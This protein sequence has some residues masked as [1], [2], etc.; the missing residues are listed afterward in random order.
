MRTLKTLSTCVLTVAL[1]LLTMPFAFAESKLQSGIT[2][3]NETQG[4]DGTKVKAKPGDVLH[5][6]VTIKNLGPDDLTDF[7]PKVNVEDLTGYGQIID[8]GD[9]GDMKGKTYINYPPILQSA[10]CGCEDKVEFR[11]KL[12]TNLC[13][14]P[15]L[16]K[17]LFP[18]V[19]FEDAAVG[20]NVECE[21]A[22]KV[23][24]P[25]VE[26]PVI[27]PP[28]EV[29]KS[30]PEAILALFALSMA[31]FGAFLYRKASL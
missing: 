17:K 16:P 3:M 1:L 2:V 26:T 12:N 24:I 7:I 18:I 30:G 23:E 5:Y 8:F 15:N 22:P 25:P 10:D 13:E 28:K 29:T 19:V 4:V 14:D 9:G 20:I 6:V 21:D 27:E 11:V 31:S